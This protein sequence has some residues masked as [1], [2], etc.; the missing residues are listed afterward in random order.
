M[1]LN[2]PSSATSSAN[3]SMQT[4][5]STLD[6]SL[7]TFSFSA[8]K[9]KPISWS[10]NHVTLYNVQNSA[11]NNPNEYHH[12]GVSPLRTLNN[13]NK[14]QDGN[15]NNN[16]NKPYLTREEQ[17]RQV[18]NELFL[19]E[20]NEFLKLS[21]QR[22]NIQSSLANR[23]GY[24]YI[25][26][27]STGLV[28]QAVDFAATC[29]LKEQIEQ[30]QKRLQSAKANAAAGGTNTNGSSPKPI[31]SSASKGPRFYL[32]PKLVSNSHSAASTNN[33]NNNNNNSK[34]QNLVSNSSLMH[35][36]SSANDE[37]LWYYYLINGC[38]ANKII[39]SGYCMAASSLNPKSPV[40]FWPNVKTTN[41]SWFFNHQ[42]QTIVSGLSEDLV[43]DY[44]IIDE[45]PNQRY[46]VIIDT[47]VPNR[48]SQK[49]SFEFC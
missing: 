7:L 39:R 10:A 48:A 27:K 19:S 13:N 11:G 4:G 12:R 32:M 35:G 15:N 29:S 5:G 22:L 40:T 25:V 26:N 44:Q 34:T 41:C 1:S 8:D 37:Q 14:Q 31:A 20:L 47:K 9:Y 17:M 6:Q 16:N 30:N 23:T 49:W 2:G 45:A 42:D 18:K 28:L 24:F 21:T 46:A 43:L 38:V 33:N 36:D 3:S